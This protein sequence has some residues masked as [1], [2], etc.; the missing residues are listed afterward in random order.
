[1]RYFFLMFLAF[2]ALPAN[3]DWTHVVD[4]TIGGRSFI[5]VQTLKIKGN[6]RRVLE[7]QSWREP[8]SDG[9]HSMVYLMEYDCNELTFR[10]LESSVHSG[11]MGNGLRIRSFP[12]DDQGKF[13]RVK[14]GTP[15]I[16]LLNY[17]CTRNK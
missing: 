15:S 8:H 10:P 5:D 11:A 14:P 1:M 16:S 17:V 3:A 9:S 2:L 7:L 12:Y 13:D 6:L 4:N